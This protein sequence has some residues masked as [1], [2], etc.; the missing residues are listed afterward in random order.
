MERT[1]TVHYET[2]SHIGF[3][4]IPY[5][6]LTALKRMCKERGHKITKVEYIVNGKVVKVKKY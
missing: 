3:T 1:Y 6:E 2:E 5:G 4:T